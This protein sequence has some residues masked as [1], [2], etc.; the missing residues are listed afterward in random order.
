MA[1]VVTKATQLAEVEQSDNQT[2][3]LVQ[4]TLK[5]LIRHFK[6]S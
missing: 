5:Q 6:V 3:A 4:S 2:E 1:A